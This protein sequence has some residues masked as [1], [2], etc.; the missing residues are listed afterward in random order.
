MRKNTEHFAQD[1]C[2]RK[3]VGYP[4]TMYKILE[5]I[6][7]VLVIQETSV[8]PG[9]DKLRGIFKYSHLYGPWHVHLVQGLSGEHKPA[10]ANEWKTYDGIIAGQMMLGLADALKQTRKPMVLMDPLDVVTAPGSPFARLSC[11]LD[12]SEA[13]GYAGASYFLEQGY[14]YLAYVGEALSRSWSVY[15]GESFMRHVAAAGREGHLFNCPSTVTSQKEAEKHLTAWLAE[16]PKPVALMAAMDTR[17]IE[18]IRLCDG[19]GLRVPTD[20][21][22]LGVDN[23]ELICNGSIPTLSSIQRDTEACGFTAAQMLDR[24]MRRE[25]Y[26]REVVRYGVQEIFTRDS[27]RMKGDTTDSVAMRARE[28]IRINAGESIGVPEIVRHLKVSRRHLEVRFRAAFNH[29]LLEEIQAVRLERAAKLLK[30]TD[31]SLTEVC[32]RSGYQT[33]VHL[34][35]VFKKHYGANMRAYRSRMHKHRTNQSSPQLHAS[36]TSAS[37]T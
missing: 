32:T 31:L 26:K 6:P 22:V 17:A 35:R 33:D 7:R 21:A 16:I 25:V 8:Q 12:D 37:S 19:I 9:R 11:T 2:H 30:E 1:A 14:Q 27:T 24:L 36:A 13:V 15:R 4:Q 29:S 34:R 10:S 5:H 28:F 18:V 3:P 20:V 23:D